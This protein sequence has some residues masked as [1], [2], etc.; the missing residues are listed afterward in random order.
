[1][2][3]SKQANAFI[4]NRNIGKDVIIY[5]DHMVF[6]TKGKA[7]VKVETDCIFPNPK[8]CLVINVNR[9]LEKD[10]IIIFRS[11]NMVKRCEVGKIST[12]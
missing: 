4:P 12:F 9:G 10:S 11:G 5:E 2:L 7:K 6:D 8:T 3:V 1:M